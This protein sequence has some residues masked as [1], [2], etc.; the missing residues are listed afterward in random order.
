MD[1]S[2]EDRYSDRLDPLFNLAGVFVLIALS[3]GVGYWCAYSDA[4]AVQEI[5]A[6]TLQNSE[7]V[8]RP[9][10]QN[11]GSVNQIA[12]EQQGGGGRR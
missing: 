2:R 9:I 11:S 5:A 10:L 12:I 1:Y 8:N 4:K 3:F 6:E 7:T